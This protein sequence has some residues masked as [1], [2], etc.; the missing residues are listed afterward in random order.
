MRD[1]LGRARDGRAVDRGNAA[2][3]ADAR[4]LLETIPVG[5]GTA[6]DLGLET[7]GSERLRTVVGLAIERANLKDAQVGQLKDALEIL[8][9]V[10]FENGRGIDDFLRG[11]ERQQPRPDVEVAPREIAKE[12]FDGVMQ[13]ELSAPSLGTNLAAVANGALAGLRAKIPDLLPD[14]PLSVGD[15]GPALPLGAETLDRLSRLAAGGLAFPNGDDSADTKPVLWDDGTSALLVFPDKVRTK[16]TDR[17][18]TVVIPVATD[19]GETEMTVPF[20]I[21]NKE[22]VAGLVAAAPDRPQGDALIADVWGEQLIAFA[23][24]LIL[25]LADTIAGASGRDI[26]NNRLVAQGLSIENGALVIQSQAGFR[27]RSGRQ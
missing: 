11:L 19:A 13:D 22:V 3:L 18:L 20:A 6:L 4:R 9:G 17:L 14:K 15:L 5:Q 1:L 2:R 12:L 10:D 27:L 8:E 26:A 16:M 24:E 21:G 7:S 25:E 23:Y